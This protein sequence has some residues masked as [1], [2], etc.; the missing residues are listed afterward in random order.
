MEAY[1]SLPLLKER[2]FI[3]FAFKAKRGKRKHSEKYSR[4]STARRCGPVE[5]TTSKRHFVWIT[6][7]RES[8][9]PPR[10][11]CWLL[12]VKLVFRTAPATA[13]SIIL[14]VTITP[15]G[16]PSN[17]TGHLVKIYLI[18][19]PR[20]LGKSMRWIPVVPLVWQIRNQSSDND[21]WNKKGMLNVDQH[22][23]F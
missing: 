9:K 22:F 5:G 18:F 15:F 11:R 14:L 17:L 13:A 7:R 1:L 23:W 8:L 12:T 6:T 19:L 10:E 21:G 4:H 3:V 20:V 16:F 2:K